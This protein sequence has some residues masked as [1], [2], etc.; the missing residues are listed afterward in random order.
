MQTQKRILL[1]PTLKL[2]R[3]Q[4]MRIR[5]NMATAFDKAIIQTKEVLVY[6][7]NFWELTPEVDDDSYY[8][9]ISA[10]RSLG[11]AVK[12]KNSTLLLESLE[13]LSE[14]I[15]KLVEDIEDD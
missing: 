6:F 10:M 11:E 1:V 9:T 13:C 4:K 14:V 3:M 5:L 15:A 7:V 12:K 8:K 2:S